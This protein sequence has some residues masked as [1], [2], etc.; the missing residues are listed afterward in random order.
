VLGNAAIFIYV[1]LF[2]PETA[3]R[4]LEELEFAFLHKVPARKFTSFI[5]AESIQAR[6]QVA[7]AHGGDG[8]QMATTVENV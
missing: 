2:V 3:N 5:S 1:Y 7:M 4:T 6:E 8:K